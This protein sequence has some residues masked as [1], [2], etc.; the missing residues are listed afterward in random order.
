MSDMRIP[1]LEIVDDPPISPH[2]F[3][4]DD[5]YDGVLFDMLWYHEH[6]GPYPELLVNSIPWI[7][8]VEYLDRWAATQAG[9]ALA[10]Y[11]IIGNDGAIPHYCVV[12]RHPDGH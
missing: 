3:M 12:R 4:T 9:V 11:R 2:A 8:V 6:S 7:D 1:L 5:P 10:Q